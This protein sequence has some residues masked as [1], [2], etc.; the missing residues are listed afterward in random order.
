[1]MG[2]V[3]EQ[4]LKR[5]AAL[6]TNPDGTT[7]GARARP[8][9]GAPTPGGDRLDELVRWWTEVTPDGLR[10]PRRVEHFW[11]PETGAAGPVRSEVV[12][13]RFTAP[14]EPGD[15]LAWGVATADDAVDDGTD[16]MLLSIPVTGPDTAWQVAAAQ[17]LGLDAVEAAGWP[18]PGQSDPEWIDRVARIR[19]GLKLVR[20][21]RRAPYR[22]LHLLARGDLWAGTG[23]LVQAAVRRTPV[24]LD[25]PAALTC[26]LLAARLA[27]ACRSWWLAA[28][29][30]RAALVERILKE[31]RVN[32]LTGLGLDDGDGVAAR[33]AL[34]QLETAVLRA[35]DRGE[36]AP[37]RPGAAIPD[38]AIPDPAIP[39]SAA[40][41][42][43]SPVGPASSPADS[44]SSPADSTS[45]PSPVTGPTS[46]PTS[47]PVGD[48]P[49]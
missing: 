27:P 47:D 34:H 33:L 42:S 43:Q 44:V 28:D 7:R 29:A 39:D 10:L 25:G 21:N 18:V 49:R 1:M 37:A 41:T 14:D 5:I 12:P 38:P 17:V 22:L 23:F 24:V 4:E 30:G 13:H 9:A 46:D 19:D 20:G 36:T 26:A 16:L 3:Q 35:L 45:G 15:A 6:V 31:L 32:P 2:A 8:R 40:P 48:G 11:L